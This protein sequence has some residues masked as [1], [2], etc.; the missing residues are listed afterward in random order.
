MGKEAL[1]RTGVRDHRPERIID[2]VRERG[3][4]LAHQGQ[5]TD[6]G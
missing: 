6:P 1:P 3:G 2:F 5:T 4:Q